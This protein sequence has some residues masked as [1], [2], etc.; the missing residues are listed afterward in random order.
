[1]FNPEIDAAA[2]S[3]KAIV[4]TSPHRARNTGQKL[5]S[6]VWLRKTNP[7]QL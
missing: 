6:W 2:T 5:S 1:L 4:I 3:K 7:D